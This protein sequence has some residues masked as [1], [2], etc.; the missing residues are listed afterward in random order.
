MVRRHA[1]AFLEGLDRIL[2]RGTV[3]GFS[4]GDL[5]GQFVSSADETAFE[6]LISRHGPMVLGVCRRALRDEQDIEDAFQAT[7]LVLV[8]RARSIRDR[9]R[10]GQW[11]HG[12]AHRVA[13][14]ARANAARR[15]VH[16]Q[17]GIKIEPARIDSPP[18]DDVAVILDNELLRLPESLRAPLVLCYLEGLTHDQAAQR[19]GWPVGTV[20]S[21]MS[22]AR[23]LLQRRLS[24]R[25]VSVPGV[26]LI[27]SVEPRELSTALINT[28]VRFALGTATKK[29]AAS[30][31]AQ[32]VL[33]AMT[34]SKLKTVGISVALGV[35]TFGGMQTFAQRL[36]A[37][38]PVEARAQTSE[39]VRD[40]LTLELAKVQGDEAALKAS[41]ARLTERK[42]AIE[43]QLAELIGTT[44]PQRDSIPKAL[45]LSRDVK[46]TVPS[47]TRWGDFIVASSPAGDKVSLY[48]SLT[49][50][51]KAVRLFES[52]EAPHK[53]IPIFNQ[54]VAALSILGPKVGRIAVFNYPDSSWHTQELREPVESAVPV[55]GT[56]IVTYSLGRYV[57]AFS[58]QA[59]RWD[60]LEL[61]EGAKPQAVVQTLTASVEHG[62]HIY[63]F[64][65]KTGKWLDLDVR[66]LL[67]A[68]ETTK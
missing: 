50:K 41:L 7:F 55:L 25:G 8:R 17:T 43:G 37:P 11:L 2:N 12:V 1:G 52:S 35:L 23:D 19:L 26:A 20:R 21:R 36:G 57:Y 6:A 49:R 29:T 24:R 4:E 51:T 42:R 18:L 58:T 63:D 64:D 34:I 22:R 15:R 45:A 53:I 32:G 10:V 47:Y 3:A 13:V 9:E 39:E 27:S 62:G 14:R 67:D 68:P 44:Q 40:R 30:L 28:T 16:E 38:Q 66:T 33:N 56:Q 60:V 48:Y 46:S 59:K 31:L 54:Q 65:A 61:P 5:L